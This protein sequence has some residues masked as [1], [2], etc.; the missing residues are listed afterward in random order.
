MTEPKPKELELSGD[1][2]SALSQ[3]LSA[4]SRRDKTRP[5]S[6]CESSSVTSLAPNPAAS[7]AADRPDTADDRPKASEARPD[8]STSE[9]RLEQGNSVGVEKNESKARPEASD[10]EARP[11]G[12]ASEPRPEAHE[13]EDAAHALAIDV[14]DYV[15]VDGNR[16]ALVQCEVPSSLLSNMSSVMQH[17]AHQATVLP[18]CPAFFFE[19]SNPASQSCW[20]NVLLKGAVQ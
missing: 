10:S 4:F 20:R 11:E 2:R 5:A 8:E 3:L 19:G 14:G 7:D 16:K 17:C 15:T 6:S 1:D 12:S 13:A 9:V 18:V